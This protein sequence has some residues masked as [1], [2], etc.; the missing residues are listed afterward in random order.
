LGRSSSPS[1]EPQTSGT[2]AIVNAANGDPDPSVQL[3]SQPNKHIEEEAIAVW[4][5]GDDLDKRMASIALPCIAN[6][7]INP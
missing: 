4:P 2:D 7:A 3:T 6:F 5:R 1:Q